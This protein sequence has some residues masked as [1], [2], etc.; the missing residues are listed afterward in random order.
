MRLNCV[1][2]VRVI[3]TKTALSARENAM[4][5]S[6]DAGVKDGEQGINCLSGSTSLRTKRR[7]PMFAIFINEKAS[8]PARLS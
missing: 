7:W 6:T 3:I 2:S 5:K 8:H 1:K 4:V